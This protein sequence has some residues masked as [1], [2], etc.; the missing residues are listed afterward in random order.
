MMAF[1][2]LLPF[3]GVWSSDAQSW[4]ATNTV[5]LATERGKEKK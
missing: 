2:V 5:V 1:F 4:M 3:L